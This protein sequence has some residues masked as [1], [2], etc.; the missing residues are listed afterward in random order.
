MNSKS[1]QGQRRRS[2]AKRQSQA[3]F[4]DKGCAIRKSLHESPF[5]S[6]PVAAT[7]ASRLCEPDINGNPVN[8]SKADVIM[9]LERIKTKE[10]G[11]RTV[12][13]VGEWTKFIN[14]RRSSRTLKYI[15]ARLN[16]W[17]KGL[18]EAVQLMN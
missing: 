7:K 11:T 12:E 14:L 2:Q 13:V 17:T 9:E 15:T 16:V 4:T 1:H 6:I 10:K 5:S 8:V 18:S 3:K